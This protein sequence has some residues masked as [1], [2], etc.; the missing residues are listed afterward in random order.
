MRSEPVM[1]NLHAEPVMLNL[2]AE[3][4]IMLNLFSP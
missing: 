3:P 2:H 1:L 4:V